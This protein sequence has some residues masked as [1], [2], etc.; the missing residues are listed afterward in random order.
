MPSSFVFLCEIIIRWPFWPSVM[1]RLMK[2]LSLEM[3][4][5]YL[6]WCQVINIPNVLNLAQHLETMLCLLI[7]FHKQNQ[8]QATKE[9]FWN[10]FL[11]LLLRWLKTVSS[12]FQDV[13]FEGSLLPSFISWC[14]NHGIKKLPNHWWTRWYYFRDTIGNHSNTMTC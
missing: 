6:I 12:T 9:Y 1:W 11:L 2:T 13:D 14:C 8:K 5:F 7:C 10:N 4:S 3:L